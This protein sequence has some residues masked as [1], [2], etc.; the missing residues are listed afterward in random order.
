M[1]P[2]QSPLLTTFTWHIGAYTITV[3]IWYHNHIV[4]PPC[5]DSRLP[6]SESLTMHRGLIMASLV[7][8][9]HVLPSFLAAFLVIRGLPEM[10]DIYP[11]A[12]FNCQS[13]S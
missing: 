5:L 10:K 2:S 7:L 3:N 4:V 11:I 1:L 12:S 8:I 9:L 13:I 6:H